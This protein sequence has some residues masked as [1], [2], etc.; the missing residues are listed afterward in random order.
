MKEKHLVAD[1]KKINELLNGKYSKYSD[2][3]LSRY[4]GITRM[5]IYNIRHKRVPVNG[6]SFRIANRLTRTYD[7]L[8]KGYPIEGHKLDD[9]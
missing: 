2:I 7:N 1:S 8:E 9:K 6:I 5:A 4:T 3:A